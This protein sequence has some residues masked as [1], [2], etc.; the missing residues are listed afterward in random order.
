ML[1]ACDYIL[2]EDTRHSRHLLDHY[3]IKKPL[4]SY[5]KFNEASQEDRIFTDLRS[6]KN[7]AIIS[8][9]GTPCI[10]DPGERIVKKCHDNDIA[11]TAIPG[12]SAVITALA[13]CGMDTEK[14]QFIGFLPKKS[15]ALKTVLL[16][17]IG[18]SGTTICYETPHRLLK[19]LEIL[20]AIAPSNIVAVCRELTKKFE[21]VRRDS[22]INQLEYWKD[23]SIKGEIVMVIA[24]GF[25]LWQD[26]SPQEHV[27]MVEETYDLPYKDAVKMVAKLRGISKNTIQQNDD[28]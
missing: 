10:A 23:R 26:L 11:V 7:I 16:D 3:D 6:G 19:S 17:A 8:D 1:K 4:F 14:F 18:Y 12:A 28:S 27:A 22:A 5:H 25:S 2:C 15:G 21:E 20:A 9:A 24:G 13:C